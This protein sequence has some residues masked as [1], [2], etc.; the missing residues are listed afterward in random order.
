MNYV[1]PIT[2]ISFYASP[3]KAWLTVTGGLFFSALGSLVVWI[4]IRQWEQTIL[5]DCH[6]Q[7]Q[8]IKESFKLPETFQENP[9][10]FL[11][12]EKL[13]LLESTIALQKEQLEEKKQ[14]MIKLSIEKESFQHQMDK[15]IEEMESIKSYC[16]QQVEEYKILLADHQKTIIDL[17]DA[18]QAKHHVTMQLESKV[19]DLSY[20]IKTILKIAEGPQ[21]VIQEAL[22]IYSQNE[23]VMTAYEQEN[24]QIQTFE[25][26]LML[27]KRS[28]DS[29]QRM[30]GPPHLTKSQHF[31][32]LPFENYALDLRRLFDHFQNE[33][34]GVLFVYSQKEEKILFVTNPIEKLIEISPEK[35]QKTFQ[36]RIQ[37]EK[38]EWQ[39]AISQLSF[40]NESKI[41]LSFKN[42]Q[43]KEVSLTCLL[44]MIPT[45][46][47]RH[48][49][50]GVL[51]SDQKISS[52]IFL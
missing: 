25:E 21:E 39:R 51:F 2:F 17:R 16:N 8:S 26:A 35:F 30:P 9:N 23:E 18:L 31:K 10:I 19:R 48:T 50:L 42:R 29:V 37:Q 33:T 36:E 13:R 41:T 47:F 32:N 40:K 44:S 38:E 4:F 34:E 43:G 7:I 1:I 5:K 45:G 46:I 14:Q 28:V 52:K 11:E 27:L 22:P 6:I 15:L 20:E 49:I 3:A 24:G 12:E